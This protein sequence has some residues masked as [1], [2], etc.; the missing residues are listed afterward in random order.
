MMN[1]ILKMLI[2]DI[3][4]DHII[5]FFWVHFE[6]EFYFIFFMLILGYNSSYPFVYTFCDNNDK[7]EL[8]P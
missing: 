4:S 8:L 6:W 1:R 7:P 3:I 2:Y 5:E